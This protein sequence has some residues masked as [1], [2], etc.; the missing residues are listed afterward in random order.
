MWRGRKSSCTRVSGNG[1]MGM[2]QDRIFLSLSRLA[3]PGCK[4][5]VQVPPNKGDVDK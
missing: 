5:S 1:K 4:F 2:K 3:C